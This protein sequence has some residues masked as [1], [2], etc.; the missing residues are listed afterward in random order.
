MGLENSSVIQRGKSTRV[1]FLMI[2]TMGKGYSN[3]QTGKS[4]EDNLKRENGLVTESVIIKLKVLKVSSLKMLRQ[5]S[6]MKPSSPL[7]PT[8]AES[9]YTKVIERKTK[10]MVK[11]S[12]NGV[13]VEYTEV[14]GKTERETVMESLGMNLELDMRVFGKMGKSMET[15]F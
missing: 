14:S 3:T 6:E 13:T 8:R 15:A 12:M 4:T 11:G 7:N 9:R 5:N 1:N 10:N 2:N